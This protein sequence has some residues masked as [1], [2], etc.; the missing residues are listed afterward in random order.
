MAPTQRLAPLDYEDVEQTSPFSLVTSDR[1]DEEW[2]YDAR[3]ENVADYCTGGHHAVFIGDHLHYGR[4]RVIHKLGIGDTAN[5]WLCRDMESK[6][7]EYC[8][9]KIL[10]ARF[11]NEDFRELYGIEIIR[12]TLGE[13]EARKSHICLPLRQFRFEG[14][15]GWHDCLVLPVLGPSVKSLHLRK[16]G[17][18]LRRKIAVQAMQAMAALHGKGIC[19]G[20]RSCLDNICEIVTKSFEQISDPK[21]FCFT[22]PVWMD[23]ARNKYSD[24]SASHDTS[25]SMPGMAMRRSRHSNADIPSH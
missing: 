20:G 16:G 23:S 1:P 22:S 7:P 18:Q 17:D 13:S 25:N 19:H 11:S 10:M 2:F 5:V 14:P 6:T 4:Y 9:V 3:L 24:V 12:S 15:N 21:I 8:A